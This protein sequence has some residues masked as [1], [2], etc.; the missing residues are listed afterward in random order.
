MLRC[1]P[2][3]ARPSGPGVAHERN[4]GYDTVSPSP[5]TPARKAA[6]RYVY[7]IHRRGAWGVALALH[8][9]K[10]VVLF[11]V[12]R[13]CVGDWTACGWSQV[14]GLAEAL[15][16]QGLFSTDKLHPIHYE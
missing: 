4:L 3:A 8:G 16:T 15:L 2:E 7:E 14:R 1:P 6:L 9:G 10:G 12:L 5:N 13:V 11:G